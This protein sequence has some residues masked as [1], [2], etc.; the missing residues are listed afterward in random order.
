MLEVYTNNE[1]HRLLEES[2]TP[3]SFLTQQEN[4]LLNSEQDE[5]TN[6]YIIFSEGALFYVDFNFIF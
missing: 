6:E 1:K 4:I 3:L 2:K 5:E